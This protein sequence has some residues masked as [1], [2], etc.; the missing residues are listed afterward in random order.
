MESDSTEP[1]IYRKL[2]QHL[3]SFPI[4]FPVTKSGVEIKILQYLFTP[5]EAEIAL[6]LDYKPEPL[7]R[8]FKRVKKSK[9]ITVEELQVIL[10]GLDKKGCLNAG[11]NPDTG[12]RF[13]ANAFLVVGMYEYQVNRLTKEFSE[14]VE[15][16]FKEGFFNEF[17]KSGVLQLRTIPIEQSVEHENFVA[18]YDEL[19]HIIE[20]RK[21]IVVSSCICRQAKKLIGEGCNSPMET[22]FQFGTA[23]YYYKDQGFGREVSK[24]EALDILEQGQK[25]GL[26]IQP[27]NSQKPIA[28]CMC[29]KCCCG[30]LTNLQ[31]LPNPADIVATNH[32]SQ[33]DAE[34]CIGCGTCVDICPMNALELGMDDKSTVNLKRCIG[35]GVC[36]AACPEQAIHLVK[37]DTE[38]VPPATNLDMYMKIME[39]KAKALQKEREE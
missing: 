29:C 13:Y 20:T 10:D 16:Y 19:R 30:V 11:K 6:F 1:E 9:D 17:T 23:A 8:I 18:T 26:V 7:H 37:R 33:V 22:C 35:C 27:S 12:E 39:G 4:G 28:L 14:Y 24:E 15:Q 21:P 38:Y 34:K 31:K 36:V 2:Q 5:E 3:D 32:R 25:A